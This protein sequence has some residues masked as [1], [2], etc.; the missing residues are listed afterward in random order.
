MPTPSN[1]RGVEGTRTH[2]ESVLM[3]HIENDRS[4]LMLSDDGRSGQPEE[5]LPAQVET[6]LVSKVSQIQQD[7]K[8]RYSSIFKQSMAKAKS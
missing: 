2:K 3:P 7:K 1:K 6:E 8:D 5:S 4:D